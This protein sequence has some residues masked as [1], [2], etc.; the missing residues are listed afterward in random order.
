MPL[1][2]IIV[3]A[4]RAE[5]F[6]DEALASA[7]AQTHADLEI[8]VVDD[9]SPDGTASRVQAHVDSDP[10]VRLLRLPVNR[11]QCAA[12]NHGLAQAAG[13]YVKFFDADD[14]ISPDFVA[15]QVAALQARPLYLAY[16]TWGRF[17]QDP[18]EAVFTPHPG[19]HD[20]NTPLDWLLETWLDTEPMYQCALF[21]IPRPLLDLAGGWDERLSLIND[22]EFFSRLVLASGGIAFTPDA[23]LF[24]RSGLPDSLSN[25]KSR[26]GCESACLSTLLGTR[27][28]LARE[29]SPRT[30]RASADML[31]ANV[32]A[33]YPMFPD[34]LEPVETEIARLGGSCLRPKG[35]RAFRLVSGVF[36]WRV[37]LRIRRALAQ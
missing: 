31:R 10:R 37:A 29:D 8:I 1:V 33:F 14:L 11:G 7:R 25:L 16:G 30:R 5:R 4:H 18:A 17:F 2:S 32:H 24:Y 22:F 23:R 28:L 35:G 13:D 15:T 27:H 21:L 20:S 34:L 12:A 6:I 3:A 36:G 19:W 26:K 9:A